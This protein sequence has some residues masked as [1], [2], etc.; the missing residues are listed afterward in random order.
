MELG[1]LP[2]F[3]NPNAGGAHQAIK[4]VRSDPRCDLHIV[5]PNELQDALNEALTQKPSTIVVAGGDG[6]VSSAASVVAGTQTALCVLRA[7]TLNHFARRI[8]IPADPTEALALAFTGET[9]WVDVGW[10]NDRLFLNTCAAGVYV[11]FVSR[12][13]RLRPKIGYV[14]SSLVAGART[15]SDFRRHR[16]DVEIDGRWSTY[17]ST[18]LFVGIGERDFRIPKVGDPMD[19]GE[20]GLHVVIAKPFSRAR[21]TMMLLR[22]PVRGIP[23]WASD[24]SVDSF[25]VEHFRAKFHRSSEKITLDGEIVEISGPLSFRLEQS[26]LAVRTPADA[27]ATPRPP[28]VSSQG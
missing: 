19:S 12:R 7:G 14:A 5:S 13:E 8:G 2:A 15:F 26:S 6:T 9:K 17:R 18:M 21:L 27:D 20:R 3:A 11:A 28:S 25:I 4:A 22:A 23:P 10:V 1:P 24:E 16:M